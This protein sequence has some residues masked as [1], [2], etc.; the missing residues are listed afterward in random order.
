MRSGEGPRIIVDV[1]RQALEGI[2]LKGGMPG[3]TTH[4]DAERLHQGLADDIWPGKA[5]FVL[6]VKWA[7]GRKPE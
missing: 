3:L 6:Q 7:W 4:E 5:L 2:V 1:M